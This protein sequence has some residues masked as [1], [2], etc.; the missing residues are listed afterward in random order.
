M[1]GVCVHMLGFIFVFGL[2]VGLTSE[3]VYVRE[4]V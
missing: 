3:R 4:E 1:F 2:F